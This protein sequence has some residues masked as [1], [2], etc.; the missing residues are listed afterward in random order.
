MV[1][2][3]AHAVDQ[4][5]EV[6]GLHVVRAPDGGHRDER[7]QADADDRRHDIDEED[8]DEGCRR[9]VVR[10]RRPGVDRPGCGGRDQGH[11]G[12]D[13]SVDAVHAHQIAGRRDLRNERRYCGHLDA[14]PRRPDGHGEEDQPY[15][16]VAVHHDERQGEGGCCDP[17][18]G[19][20]D[21]ILAVVTVGPD[22]AEDRD[23]RLGQ[24]PEQRR[25]HHDDARAVLDRQ[26]P[27]HGVLDEHRAEQADGLPAQEEDDLPQPVRRVG[28]G[29][30]GLGRR[31]PGI[32]HL[33][34]GAARH[35]CLTRARPGVGARRRSGR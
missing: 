15:R 3:V 12:L 14:G 35:A 29:P 9:A 33:V 28:S 26:V 7:E 4:V 11:R 5:G 2:D 19:R 13:R 23:H 6:P 1:R 34:V 17:R 10:G 32:P 24:E 27:E 16:V 18:I 21:Q 31:A 20:H 30:G 22:P 8:R 25:Q